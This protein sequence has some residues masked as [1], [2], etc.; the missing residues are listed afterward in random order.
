[1]Q[2]LQDKNKRLETFQT[3]LNENYDV[4]A[5]QE[6][7]C[8]FES[9]ETWKE[10]WGG[11]SIWST[12]KTDKAGTA[13]LFNPKLQIKILEQK[14]DKLGRILRATVEIENHKLQIANIYGPNPQNLQESENFFH[15]IDEFL[16][17]RTEPI[18]FGDF[19]MVEDLLN[20]RKG[21]TPKKRHSYGQKSLGDLV[22]SF[23][24]VDIWRH[25][26]PDKNSFT[27][28][29]KDN[30]IRSRLDR[31]YL[32]EQL[33]SQIDNC[34]IKYFPW[35]DHDLCGIKI[36][37]PNSQSKGKGFWCL[38]TQFLEHERYQ[39][40]IRNFWAEWLKNKND[41]EDIGLWWDCFKIYVKSISIEYAHQIHQI[42]KSKK[43]NLL[44]ELKWEREKLESN[45]EKLN[46]IETELQDIER[47]TN[48]KIFIHTRTSSREISEQPNKYFYH[49]LRTQQKHSSMDSLL[50]ADETIITEQEEMMEETKKFYQN[51]Y[52]KKDD[53][54]IEDQ[55][56][57]LSKIDSF[58]SPKQKS[59]L[60]KI[61]EKEEIEKALLESNKCKKPGADGLPYEFYSSFWDII[62]DEFLNVVNFSLNEAKRLPYSQSVSIITLS[63]KKGDRKLLKNWR[64]ISLLCCDYKIIS[65]TLANRMKLVLASVISERQTCSV[66]GRCITQNLRFMRDAIFFCDFNKINGYILSVDQE[67][68][69]DMLDRDFLV[70][71]L[72]KMNFG[73][74]FISWIEI[75]YKETIGRIL[76]N[77]YISTDFDITRGVR[78]GCP[79]SAYV[80]ATYIEPLDNAI[81]VDNVII[82][83]PIPGRKAPKTVLY[84]DDLT[85]A[86]SD[87]TDIRRVLEIFCMF[88]RATGSK[89]NQGKTQG[90][91]LNSPKLENRIFEIINW[92]NF[93]GI[94]I[95]GIL[96]H[97]KYDD[98]AK[99]VWSKIISKMSA[100]LNSIR[101]RSLSLKG[102]IIVL[103]T[104]I[105]SKAWYGATIIDIPE[106]KTKEIERIALKFLWNDRKYD[107]VTK[108]L[109]NPI[110][111]RTLYQMRENGGL[112][113][114][115]P[116]IQQ[117]ALQLK[118]FKEILD[119][120]NKSPCLQLPRYWIGFDLACLNSQW[121]FLRKYPRLGPTTKDKARPN[122]MV[123]NL[124]SFKSIEYNDVISND[125]TVR[126]LYL[127]FLKKD[128]HFPKAYRNFW[129]ARQVDPTTMWNHIHYSLALGIHQD[130]HY[131][132]LH[133]VLPTNH[134]KKI[135]FKSKG[136]RN[137]NPICA[138]CP[139]INETNEHVF[140][141]CVAANPIMNF[142]RKSIRVLLNGKNFKLL[143][144][145]VNIFPEN[146]PNK[147]QKMVVGLL[148]IAMYTI[149]NNRN[150]FK[151]K[152]EITHLSESINFIEKDFKSVLRHKFDIL[153][154]QKFKENFC[155][156][157]QICSID[158]EGNILINLI[159]D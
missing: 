3:L 121:H 103:N 65:K 104:L 27:W 94:E 140:F 33:I 24:L 23:E 11:T 2:G 37:L 76:L 64:P 72:R 138:S 22:E 46:K 139:E 122:Y 146:T 63:Y 5:L 116:K 4:I 51:L 109:K 40:K 119:S 123:E 49:I 143:K 124:N 100:S 32:P 74:I 56:F 96:F 58:I 75:L 126:T 48:E 19:N 26:N 120:E 17:P 68:A 7:H 117:T 57:F 89:I 80:Y 134:Y 153:G 91:A 99:A 118:F 29:T 54:S 115:N 137:T 158:D 30:R 6:T 61:I 148:Q 55:N 43:Y 69:F 151:F 145:A 83:I 47:E 108:K 21:G 131:R 107:P 36:S 90:L 77:G 98:T 149:W 39:E 135:T 92:K 44:D 1:M 38:N 9:V 66:P 42:R 84:A 159:N 60:D 82:C 14:S 86:L 35:S 132:F 50:K 150:R 81:N 93:E 52:K 144:I 156:T 101:Y 130:V 34:Y 147:I 125:W 110:A 106:E 16:D 62:G 73:E 31:I 67:K 133:R 136:F 45:T 114:I 155:H 112:S 102:K 87:K 12:Y 113:L 141:R 142:I 111:R 95:L 88:E 154:E 53:I 8:D 129:N 28:R 97:T 127:K 25:L 15:S 157:P 41:F 152:E 79:L 105:L 70:K 128:E 85:L 13:F 59:Q 20:D 18:I 71:V 10:E 78:Q